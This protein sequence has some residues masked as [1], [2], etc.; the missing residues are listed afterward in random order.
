LLNLYIS[1]AH[2]LM[3]RSRQLHLSPNFRSYLLL[4]YYYQKFYSVLMKI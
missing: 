2:L 1:S 4:L 3:L